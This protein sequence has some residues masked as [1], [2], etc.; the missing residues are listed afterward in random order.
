MGRKELLVIPAIDLKDGC[1]VRLKQGVFSKQTVYSDK[2]D[3][4]AQI[5]VEKG[6][7]RLH[8]VDLDGAFEGRPSNEGVIRNIMRAT[9]VPIQLGGGIRDLET[10][11]HY[12][13]IGISFVI[14]GTAAYKDPDLLRAACERYPGKI[15]LGLDAKRRYVAI[16]GWTQKTHMTPVQ[17][18]RSYEKLGISA[19]IY[20]DIERDGMGTGP[21][22]EATRELADAIRTPVVASGGISDLNDVR[23]IRSLGRFGVIGMITG[24][25]LYEGTLDLSDAIRLAKD[26]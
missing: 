17:M 14:L 21:N 9:G 16:Q 1:C 4:I 6:A 7:E 13:S 15:I 12:F 19:I 8:I 18:A 3:E 24:R 22:V 2:P 5:W 11:E 25:A 26:G 23:A 20:T 10:I